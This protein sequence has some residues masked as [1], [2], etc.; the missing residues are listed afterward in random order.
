MTVAA[1]R[2][3]PAHTTT[4]TIEY[5]TTTITTI[6][7]EDETLKALRARAKKEGRSVSSLIAAIL[8]RS[9]V[10]GDGKRSFVGLLQDQPAPEMEDFRAVRAQLNASLRTKATRPVKAAPRT[11]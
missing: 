8:Q 10:E 6:R 1:P 5:V 11:R 9:V 3:L 7:L 4:N 2:R